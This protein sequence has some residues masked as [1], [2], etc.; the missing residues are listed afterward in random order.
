MQRCGITFQGRRL[1][2]RKKHQADAQTLFLVL[3]GNNSDYKCFQCLA[4]ED[5][6]QIHI[7]QVKEKIESNLWEIET[8]EWKCIPTLCLD[9]YGRET[10]REGWNA[11]EQKHLFFFPLTQTLLRRL[12]TKNRASRTH[13]VSRKKPKVSHPISLRPLTDVEKKIENE[14]GKK[15]RFYGKIKQQKKRGETIYFMG[16]F[17][18]RV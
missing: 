16:W 15:Q 17:L 14:K 7:F 11:L 8:N 18:E 4:R 10:K 1:S 13:L 3:K 9:L 5:K 2:E 6:K 12:L